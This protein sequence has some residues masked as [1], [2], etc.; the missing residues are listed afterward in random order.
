[1]HLNRSELNLMI[2]SPFYRSVRLWALSGEQLLELVGHTAIV[3]SVA[4]HSSGDIASGSED[5][6]AKIWKGISIFI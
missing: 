1:M 4:A 3:Y 5:G 6:F 2:V